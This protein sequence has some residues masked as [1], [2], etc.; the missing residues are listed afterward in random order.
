MD[1][2]K[3]IQANYTQNAYTL[4]VNP[5]PAAGG[6]ITKNPAQSTYTHGQEVILTAAPN[7]NY[8]FLNW[9]GDT[10]GSNTSVTVI[11]NGNKTVNA[12]FAALYDLTVTLAPTAGGYIIK[13]PDKPRYTSGESV[14]IT[15]YTNTGYE[16]SGWTG[17]ASSTN[18]SVTI[19]M[20]SNKALTANFA[21]MYTLTRQTFGSGS[22]NVNPNNTYYS[23]GTSVSVTAV[24]LSGYVLAYWSGDLTGR[25]NPTSITMNNNKSITAT[26]APSTYT[27]NASAA[28]NGTISPSGTVTVNYGA[29]QTFNITP[30]TGYGVQDVLVDG[31]SV[32]AVSSYI[33][34]NVTGNHTISA[35]FKLRPQLTSPAAGTVINTTSVR[36][37]WAPV[38]NANNGITKYF[39][40]VG[41]S[42]GSLDIFAQDFSTNTYAD[43]PNI[44]LNGNPIY[45]KLAWSTA[46][47]PI[48]PVETVN[49]RF[50]TQLVTYTITS[51]AGTGGTISPNGSVSVNYGARQDFYIAANS[52]YR[53]SDVVVD[54]TSIGAIA[55]PTFNLTHTLHNVKSNH[56]IQASFTRTYTISASAGTGGT[57]TPSGSVSVD[58]GAGQTFS[59]T[60]NTGYRIQNVLVDGS[61]VGAVSTYPFTNVTAHHTIYASFVKT[62]T[63]TASAGTG[64]TITPSGIITVDY[65]TSKTFTI[66]P[67]TGYR[68]QDVLVN[69]T[70][71]GATSTVTYNY[72]TADSTI[73][74]SFALK[75]Y[76]ITASAGTGGSISPSGSVSVNHGTNKTFSIT[77]NTGYRIVDVLVD[78][79]S[80]GAVSSYTFSN[81]TAG[82]TI[83]TSFATNT[84]TITASAGTGGTIS[85]SGSVSVN[86]GAGQTFSI[87]A[88]AGYLIQ[89][90]L[91]DGASVGAVS[92]YPF[93]AVSANHTIAVSFAPAS[94]PTAPSGLTAARLSNTSISLSWTDNSNNEA[95]FKIIRGPRDFSQPF[96]VAATLEAGVTTYTDTGLTPETPYAYLVYAY[97]TLG[98]SEYSNYAFASTSTTP[99][100][101]VPSNL[102][103]SALSK[104]SIKLTWKDNSSNETGF[105]IIRGLADFS[106]PFVTVAKLGANVKTYTDTGLTKDTKYAYLI[107]AY[108][109]GGNSEYSN[110]AYAKTKK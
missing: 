59:I 84:Y 33:F 74:A 92:S 54:G 8:A 12:N 76:T 40:Y 86:Y 46:P 68:I 28:T 17:S 72:V 109:N 13:S 93:T 82:H 69:G 47:G 66:T 7:A 99:I 100:P 9:S 6:S 41:T 56:T 57:I 26:F 44:P 91:V 36:F 27:I 31:T 98:N 85:P 1:K 95:G 35:T 48:Y 24:P 108:N 61:S 70:S 22:I 89:N 30:N 18:S 101:A 103:G 16:F 83:S 52:G 51:S 58:S 87:A 90:V 19:T 94:K 63:I 50:D 3:T 55:I 37:E 49:Y 21:Q 15:A 67:N 25:Q 62:C 102:A 2:N 39:L 65:G 73:Q 11:M 105:V 60:P 106:Q 14:T 32:G 34:N 4:T 88:N 71:V 45:V 20:D 97:N 80:V 53:L 64:G 5:I 110:Y 29:S 75:T 96:V 43:V 104:T 38:P 77:P 79:S 81:V 107:Y 23:S 42:Q 10:G 78:G